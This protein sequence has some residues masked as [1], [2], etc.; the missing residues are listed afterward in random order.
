M[1]LAI[2]MAY[3]ALGCGMAVFYKEKKSKLKIM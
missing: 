3:V 1:S 2:S